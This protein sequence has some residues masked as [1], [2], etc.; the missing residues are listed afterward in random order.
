MGK[1]QR[2]TKGFRVEGV[3]EVMERGFAVK[4]V[5]KRL[6]V[7]PC[8]LCQRIKRYGIPTEERLAKEDQARRVKKLEAELRRVTEERDVLKEPWRTSR[9][10]LGEVRV[11]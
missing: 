6:G 8:N 1:S 7:S 9:G 2:F 10:S 11:Y 4:D 5:S 3:K